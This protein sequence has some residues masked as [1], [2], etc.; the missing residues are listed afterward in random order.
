MLTL[1]RGF[2][3][4]FG[5][6]NWRLA[7]DSK[8]APHRLYVPSGEEPMAGTRGIDGVAHAVF[9]CKDGDFFAQPVATCEMLPPDDLLEVL[10][11]PPETPEPKPTV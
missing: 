5:G 6:E 7:G 3:R 9:R 1:K 10:S 4:V 8:W 11:H 2:G